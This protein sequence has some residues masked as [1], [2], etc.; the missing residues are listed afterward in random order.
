M[1]R[2]TSGHLLITLI[3]RKSNLDKRLFLVTRLIEHSESSG[4][5]VLPSATVLT[6]R[7]VS[8][9]AFLALLSLKR[10][11][12]CGIGIVRGSGLS[13]CGL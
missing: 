3:F 1:F 2:V 13:S 4:A 9:K 8:S 6:G 5:F 12:Y 10:V 7:V 11:G